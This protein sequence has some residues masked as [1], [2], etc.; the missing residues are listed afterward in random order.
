MKLPAII[1]CCLISLLMLTE[2]S[3][4]TETAVTTIQI[5]PSPQ[6]ILNKLSTTPYW[7]ATGTPSEIDN[8]GRSLT[9]LPV[10]PDLLRECGSRTL[11][12]VKLT[13]AKNS[14]VIHLFEFGDSSGAFSLFS[15]QNQ[16]RERVEA[17]GD[18]SI[19]TLNDVWLWQANLV[20]HLRDAH[21]SGKIKA[22]LIELGK[23]TSKLIRQRSELPSLMKLLPFHNQVAGSSRYVLGQQG[24]QS[25]E[26]PVQA[27]RLG[28]EMGAEV[29]AAKY[30]FPSGIVQL[31][32]I[33]YPTPQ[34]ARKFYPGIQD[35]RSF[36][37]NATAQDKVFTKRT[38]PLV[39]A[40]L[41][42]TDE[43]EANKLL[44]VIQYSANLTWDETP[45]RDAQ[46]V[47][48]YLREV[49]RSFL[50][51]GALLLVTIGAGVLFGFLR[52]AI[53]KWAP[54]AI[55]DRPEDVEL[56][57]LRLGQRTASPPRENKSAK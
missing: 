9:T 22:Q 53:K 42:T 47:S 10:S 36:L 26:I 5:F 41:G 25:L 56:I 27:S 49:V 32:L 13:R 16:P 35:T 37:Q 28:F 14:V 3:P 45:P 24:L 7:K 11:W 1:G 51:T 48:N 15:L 8:L 33:S 54:I 57:Q 46:E 50:L 21:Q 12:Q 34:M 31:L 19:S 6:E 29:S 39:A 40:I 30:Q 43:E 2:V 4:A 20:V 44:K 55:F 23:E 38:G 17:F 52:V 18:Q